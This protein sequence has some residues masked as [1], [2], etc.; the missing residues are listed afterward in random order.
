[1]KTI[2]LYITFLFLTVSTFGQTLSDSI[3]DGVYIQEMNL[4]NGKLELRVP[5]PVNVKL[6]NSTGHDIDTLIFYSVFF[7]KLEK[8]SSTP[9]FT[10]PNYEDSDFVRGSIQ[11]LKVDN[12]N[13]IWHCKGVPYNYENKTLII[14][15]VLEE[16]RFVEENY[17]L[18]TRIKE[19]SE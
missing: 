15:I 10:I 12:V 3:I 14:E 5:N 17:R 9:F 18:E 6:I 7:P 2:L 13:W 19:I 8:D 1:M 16:S 11:N 4:I